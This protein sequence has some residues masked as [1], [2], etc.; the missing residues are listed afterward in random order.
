VRGRTVLA[1]IPIAAAVLVFGT[2]FG[3]VATPL[4]GPTLTLVASAV[5]FSGSVQFAMAAVLLSGATPLAAVL[6]PSLLNLRNLVLGAV[7]RP[8]VSAGPLAR[9][10]L[11]WF[12]TEEAVG[13]ALASDDRAESVV[14]T[15]G[16]LLY[17]SWVAGTALGV[18]GASLSG[19]ETLAEA[20]FPV[21]FIGL[22][23]A[24]AT[25]RDVVVRAVAA[26]GITVALAALF[27]AVRGLAPVAAVIV[28]AVPGRVE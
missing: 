11:G 9:A 28:V 7:L 1:T 26:A 17:A 21:L 18:L 19:L 27:P 13:L 2:I 24:A 20:V 3:A 8:R 6:T 10:G 5:V 15:A 23:A 22:A 16:I 14:L 25:R 4:I 12:L